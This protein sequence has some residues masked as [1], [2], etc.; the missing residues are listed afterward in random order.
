MWAFSNRYHH[1]HQVGK[2]QKQTPFIEANA[3]IVVTAGGDGHR[4]F[5]LGKVPRYFRSR[6]SMAIFPP[7]LPSPRSSVRSSLARGLR[8]DFPAWNLNVRF[9]RA[10]PLLSRL[11][12]RMREASSIPPSLPPHTIP[13]MPAGDVLIGPR[14]RTERGD[15]SICPPAIGGS[16]HASMRRRA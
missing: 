2:I 16:I 12:S 9:P 3:K 10:F 14:L 6:R 11:I 8:G 13:F 15:W 4:R 1:H 5:P 7:F